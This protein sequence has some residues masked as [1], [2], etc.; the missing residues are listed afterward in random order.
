VD[1]GQIVIAP[2]LLS[3]KADQNDGND[4]YKDF[5]TVPFFTHLISPL[6]QNIPFA[7]K[8]YRDRA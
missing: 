8:Y 7:G 3:K 4:V 6:L 1:I 2:G 5:Q